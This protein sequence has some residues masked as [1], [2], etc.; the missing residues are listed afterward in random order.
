LTIAASCSSTKY[1]AE[2]ERLYDKGHVVIHS[3]DTIPKDRKE[4]FETH[5]QEM[6]RPKPN[7]KFLGMRIKLGLYNMGGGPDSSSGF[8]GRWLKRQGEEPVLLSDVNREY[9]ENL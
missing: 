5:L 6:L 7:K 2:D 8:I 3:E 4:A 9:N 1:L